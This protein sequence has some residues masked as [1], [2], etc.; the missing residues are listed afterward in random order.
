MEGRVG[1]QPLSM[2][3]V[4]ATALDVRQVP[5]TTA[6]S[7]IE[8]VAQRL[9][10]AGTPMESS[11][12]PEERSIGGRTFWSATFSVRMATGI[13]Y[14]SE[15]VTV[16]KGYLLM[17]VCGGPDLASLSEIEKSLQSIHFLN[18]SK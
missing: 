14:V 18:A 2:K 12:P 7:Y 13:R 15:I 5:T 9:K 1:N 17:F 4:M 16:D 8:A 6:Q 3:T 11:S 10:Q